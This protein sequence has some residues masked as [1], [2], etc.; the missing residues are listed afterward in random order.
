MR[1]NLDTL[2]PSSLVDSEHDEGS[3]ND[4]A[5]THSVPKDA[6]GQRVNFV[7]HGGITAAESTKR[8]A[9]KAVERVARGEDIQG[10]IVGKFTLA[11][12]AIR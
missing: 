7:Q 5:A 1:R 10:D 11:S 8:V 6:V 9:S 12:S 4:W 2:I 3:K